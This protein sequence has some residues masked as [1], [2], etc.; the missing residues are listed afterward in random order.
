MGMI[1]D[2]KMIPLVP[3]FVEDIVH[4]K[5]CSDG[6]WKKKHAYDLNNAA[7]KKPSREM[8]C[9]SEDENMIGDSGTCLSLGQRNRRQTCQQGSQS[10]FYP[11]TS[12]SAPPSSVKHIQLIPPF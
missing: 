9:V 2:G 5:T 1:F 11:L 4:T 7:T 3:S 8:M 6:V 12:S 10:L